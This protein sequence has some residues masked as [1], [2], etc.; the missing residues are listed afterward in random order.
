MNNIII[1]ILLTLIILIVIFIQSIK[2]IEI[3]QYDN[4]NNKNISIDELR[5]IIEIQYPK[6]EFSRFDNVLNGFS[7]LIDDGFNTDA[8]YKS[9]AFFSGIDATNLNNTKIY[10]LLSGNEMEEDEKYLYIKADELYNRNK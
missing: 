6:A 4:I 5:S 2:K 1:N 3:E 10:N 8:L 7:N 9:L